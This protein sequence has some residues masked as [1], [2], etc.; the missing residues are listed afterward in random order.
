MRTP[1]MQACGHVLQDM[2]GIHVRKMETQNSGAHHT[3][4][5]TLDNVPL[6]IA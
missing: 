6:C 4:F 2:P 5:I 3:S 1:Q